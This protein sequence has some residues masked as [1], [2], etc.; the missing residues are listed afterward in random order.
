[1]KTFVIVVVLL[2]IC[3]AGYANSK[4]PAGCAKVGTDLVAVFTSLLP[5]FPAPTPDAGTPPAAPAAE[6]PTPAPAPSAPP[7]AP[8]AAS[9]APPPPT[10]VAAAPAPAPTP[11]PDAPKPWTPPNPIPS[12]PNWTWTTEDGKTYQNVTITKIEPNSVTITHS[13]GV[14]HIDPAL[15]PPDIQ[16]QL[17]YDPAARKA[18]QAEAEAEEWTTDYPAALA[19]AKAAG[20][21]VLLDFTGS[22]WC[23]YCQALEMEVLTQPAFKTFAAQNYVLVTLDFPRQTTLPAGLKQ[24]NDALHQQFSI[25]GYPTLIVVDPQ[26][27][28]LGRQVGYNPGSGPDAI[29]SVLK[30]FNKS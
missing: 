20:K 4:N 16:K 24:Q 3:L 2:L 1:M 22:D 21:L 23:G 6:A 19:Q 11:S 12:Q 10:P 25:T 26:G 17:N 28:E 5:T 15:L 27:K 30:S 13:M 18:A 9:P 7:P 29:I 8:V 14:S